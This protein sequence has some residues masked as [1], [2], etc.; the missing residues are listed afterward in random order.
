MELFRIVERQLLLTLVEGRGPNIAY[1]SKAV[2]WASIEDFTQPDRM[3][4]IIE[5]IKACGNVFFIT[6]S[7]ATYYIQCKV[8][9]QLFWAK[10]SA[11]N[12]KQRYIATLL[13]VS[14]STT[15]CSQTDEISISL[16]VT[17]SDQT[18][19]LWNLNHKIGCY[20]LIKNY[21]H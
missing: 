18:C 9:T 2:H 11:F 14:A 20:R 19:Q 15:F 4:E 7:A 13:K 21:W 6:A 10:R 17:W 8:C 12:L 5:E 16:K 3:M 1:S